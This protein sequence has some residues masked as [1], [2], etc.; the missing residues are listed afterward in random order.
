MFHIVIGLDI[1]YQG[2]SK[3]MKYEHFDF[4]RWWYSNHN[5]PGWQACA[6]FSSFFASRGS[7]KCIRYIFMQLPL[8]NSKNEFC[9]E[10]PLSNFIKYMN[11]VK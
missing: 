10:L 2:V 6:S 8:K 7:S 4:Y 3:H 5:G 11:R 1:L 9:Q